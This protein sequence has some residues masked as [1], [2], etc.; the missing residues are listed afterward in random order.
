MTLPAAAGGLTTVGRYRLVSKLGEGGMGVVY[1][2]VGEAGMRVALKLLAPGHAD[3]AE[4]RKR[5]VREARVM[6]ALE[7]PGI[8]RVLDAGE[9]DGQAFLA[10]ELV[11][12]ASLKR[13]LAAAAGPLPLSEALR[14]ARDTA[15]AVAFAH[16][17]GVV[18][19]DLKPDNLMVSED[20]SVRV[21]DFGLAKLRERAGG[22]LYDAPT[23]SS[24][25]RE[26]G[27][28]GT[29]AYMSPEQAL[30]REVGFPTDVFSLGVLLYEMATGTRPFAGASN[31]EIIVSVTR[32][33]PVLPS[34]RNPQIP[35]PVDAVILACLA[36]SAGERPEMARLATDLE[37]LLGPGAGQGPARARRNAWLRIAAVPLATAVA[38]GAWLVDRPARTPGGPTDTPSASGAA[39]APPPRPVPTA[40]TDLPVPS[41][42][43]EAIAAYVAGIRAQRDGAGDLAL[44]KLR[45][46]TTLDPSITVAHLRLADAL[47]DTQALSAREHFAKA[48]D[49]EASLAPRDRDYLEAL[50]PLVQHDPPDFEGWVSRM[51]ALGAAYPGDAEILASL[52]NA[53]NVMGDFAAA[54]QTDRLA[55]EDDPRFG[56]AWTGLAEALAYA[57]DFA[58]AE[59]AV[60]RCLELLPDAT[61]CVWVR[62][63]IQAQQGDCVGWEAGTR[64]RIATQ[65]AVMDGYRERALAMAALGANPAL[66]EEI[67]RQAVERIDDPFARQSFALMQGARFAALGGHFDRAA[68]LA[69]DLRRHV[70][71]RSDQWEHAIASLLSAEV[72]DEI[73]HRAQAARAAGDFLAR[74]D[75]WQ[76]DEWAHDYSLGWDFTPELLAI[77]RDDGAITSAEMRAALEPWRAAWEAKLHGGYRPYL[78]IFGW[79]TVVG[80]APD[81]TEALEA[82]PR[83]AP[84]PTFIPNIT[85]AMGFVGRTYALG[86]RNDMAIE[87]LRAAAR[88]CQAGTEPVVWV[89]THLW[90]GEAL[91]TAG[92]VAG[93]CAA[94]GDV[95]AR[96]GHATPPSLTAARARARTKALRCGG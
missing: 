29:P 14:I 93:A 20:G 9:A 64:Q 15:H 77:R 28:L 53:E 17:R 88:S 12:G 85:A 1:E 10:M 32:D 60:S 66:V 58:G 40:I 79:A 50:R 94:Y 87:T 61:W 83:Y 51:R 19:R 52:A 74:R 39:A 24:V 68:S 84:L 11:R 37:R 57:G 18:H 42:K 16:G 2:A 7:H 45:Q 96:W 44:V 34:K 71:A 36:K 78:W 69:A 70:A 80:S 56:F 3:D 76:P 31:V 46:A 41:G 82:L 75:A 8:A 91:E 89:R 49:D 59:R 81:A 43:P 4:R 22:I 55:L 90:L 26:G 30:G 21:L 54:A 65:P 27:V 25:T 33:E 73:G 6:T 5:F 23:E 13:R 63:A 38:L 67:L 47:S 72:E 92:D 86:G 62:S 95:V 48:A 35:G